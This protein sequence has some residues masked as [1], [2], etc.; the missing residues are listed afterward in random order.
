MLA[1]INQT[2]LSNLGHDKGKNKF[3]LVIFFI[4][5]SY[6][7]W[8]V[9]RNLPFTSSPNLIFFFSAVFV[10]GIGLILYRIDRLVSVFK[11][12]MTGLNI[13]YT[14]LQLWIF[15]IVPPSFE[16][17]Y[18]TLAI[19]MIYLNGRLVLFTGFSL[20][21]FTMLGYQQ[22]PDIF[23]P[24]RQAEFSNVSVGLIFQTTLILW[25]ATQIGHHLANQMNKQKEQAL[26]K[27]EELQQA[28]ALIERTIGKLQS[29]FSMLKENIHIS[30]QSSEEIKT[31]F[32]EV[33]AGTQS[34][35]QSVSQSA[36]QLHEMEMITKDILE[37]VKAVAENVNKSLTVATSSK[38]GI[39]MFVQ[40]MN[41]LTE[42][43]NE[44]G[45]V[46]R[47]LSEQSAK[48]NEIVKL[49]TDIA[50]QTN[51]LAL[52]A[53]IEA[54]RAGEQGKGFA[55]VADEVRKLAERSQESAENIQVILRSFKE[56][57]ELVEGKI[58]QGKGVQVESNKIMTHVF[59]D[60][61]DLSRFISDIDHV[62]QKIVGHQ[63]QFKEKTSGIVH[64][65]GIVSS[66]TEETSAA[67]EQVLASVEEEAH[68]IRTSV[69]ALESVENTID[70]LEEMIRQK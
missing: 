28:Y 57:A 23:F 46:V 15:N 12:I 67:T 36:E 66:V 38:S 25:A 59:A 4:T 50:S 30:S 44:T 49:I 11:Y 7:E 70:E 45:A 13:F 14:I 68:R 19:T 53:A 16:V 35:A 69:T 61:D 65:I 42:V 24:H 58:L 34:Q 17:V 6:G 56:Q 21:L 10:F 41:D 43:V 54:A 2:F 37:K 18:F 52:N 5:Y 26:R 47:D 60:V 39:Q 40:H 9:L 32:R 64:D 8:N 62:M 63:Q 31:A 55:V 48:I 20:W 33:A 27:T 51:L 3:L 22:W 29:N 1:W